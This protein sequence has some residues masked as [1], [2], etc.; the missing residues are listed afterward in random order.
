MTL[1]PWHIEFKKPVINQKSNKFLILL[2][3]SQTITIGMKEKLK[4]HPFFK[5]IFFLSIIFLRQI[6]SENQKFTI[7]RTRAE[8][9]NH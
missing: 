8:W 9:R 1:D 6:L 2:F 5:N 7:T 4:S 3:S